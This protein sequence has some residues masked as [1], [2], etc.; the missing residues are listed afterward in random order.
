MALIHA[1]RPSSKP[2]AD[3]CLILEGSYPYV[4]GGVS[5]W[6]DQLIRSFPEK[7]FHLWC[8]VASAND[9]VERY[10]I[11][12]NVVDIT[13]V[14]IFDYSPEPVGTPHRKLWETV[15]ALYTN[16]RNLERFSEIFWGPL[17]QCLPRTGSH[18]PIRDL[19]L[20]EQAYGLYMKFCTEQQLEISLIDTYYAFLY[21]L[22]PLLRLL[23]IDIPP[24]R[25]YH[26]ISTGYA[27][28]VG[29]RAR[30]LRQAPLLLTEHGIYTSERR[31]EISMADWIYTPRDEA[32]HCGARDLTL[33]QLWID[34]F[35]FLGRMTYREA[36]RITTL[37]GGNRDLQVRL[38][39]PSSKIDIIPNGIKL[40]NYRSIIRS[41]KPDQ[42]VIGLVGRVVPIK[43]IRTFIKACRVVA[44]VIPG[45]RFLVLGSIDQDPEYYHKC[46]EYRKLADLEG[47]LTFTGNVSLNSYYSR[48]DVVVL[49]SVSEAMPLTILEAMA[50]GIP[51]V[52]TRVGA[53]D[54]LVNG[55][56]SADCALG[57][58]GFTADVADNEAIGRAIIRLLTHPKLAGECGRIGKERVFRYYD[59]E[60]VDRRYAALYDRW[61]ETAG[62]A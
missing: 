30:R 28:F 34:M 6:A 54:E 7:T 11:P 3:V 29:C 45:A 38:G 26:A 4:H 24:A 21:M 58:S 61:L 47:K 14:V 39:A 43:D 8:L 55:R 53:C 27:G 60:H 31:V 44:S 32:I 36:D 51:V 22:S 9:I 12:S 18:L 1:P 10:A 57:A 20:G 35:D 50:C 46:L 49:T 48:L 62:V 19:L 59:A 40:S 16:R 5:G 42:P 23:T 41:T 17:Q 37:C 33:K 15:Y 52:T 25:L 13:N 56:D 2:V